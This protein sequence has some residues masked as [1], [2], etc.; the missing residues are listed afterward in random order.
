MKKKIFK[1][2]KESNIEEI[3]KLNISIATS[4]SIMKTLIDAYNVKFDIYVLTKIN[5]TELKYL[6]LS[7]IKKCRF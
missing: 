5:F 4:Y 3:E 1:E 2:L 6:N 7:Y